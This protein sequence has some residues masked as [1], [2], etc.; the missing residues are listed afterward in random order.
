MTRNFG[1]EKF[2]LFQLRKFHLNELFPSR[3]VEQYLA[4]VIVV[5]NFEMNK[6]WPVRKNYFDMVD[7]QTKLFE[8]QQSQL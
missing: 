8:C 6:F 2:K 4:C 5:Y 3:A 7:V 1:E